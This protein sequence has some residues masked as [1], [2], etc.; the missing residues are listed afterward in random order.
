MSRLLSRH[1]EAVFWMGRQVE[2][3]ENVARLIDILET[4]S[5][6]SRGS[7]DWMSLLRIYADE[8]GFAARELPATPENVLRFYL[9]DRQNPSSIMSSL[10]M[11][12]ENARALRPL[13]STEMWV[14]INMVYNRM[15]NLKRQAYD[16]ENLSRLCAQIKEACQ[17]HR[18]ILEGTFHRD[19]G[20]YFYQIGKDLERAD[21]MTRLVDV[22]YH[23]LLPRD[24]DIGSPFDVSQWN[25]VLRSAAAYHAFRQ[26]YPSGMSAGRVAGFLLLNEQFPRSVRASIA[27]AHWM[28]QRM[29]SR[30]RIRT[31]AETQAHLKAFAD[32]LRQ[33]RIERLIAV[34]L[35]EQLDAMQ[36]RIVAITNLLG[37]ELFGHEVPEPY[38][39]G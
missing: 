25:A 10:H 24:A 21:Q 34:G 6:D 36:A 19:E 4:F 16:E 39:P 23:T 31:G 18:G 9:V 27:E 1:A 8:G 37:R 28:M 20:W 12:R 13:I 17:A 22:K 15:R 30:H 7:Q 14:Q 26:I 38:G 35:H 5:R 11:A 3:A 2:R 29:R 33:E 32:S